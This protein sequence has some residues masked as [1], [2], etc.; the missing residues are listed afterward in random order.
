MSRKAV[1]PEHAPAGGLLGVDE[2]FLAAYYAHVAPEDLQDYSP[3]NLGTAGAGAMRSW[4]TPVLPGRRP[5][6]S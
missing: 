1:H 2:Q 4:R 5:S 6:I 3:E